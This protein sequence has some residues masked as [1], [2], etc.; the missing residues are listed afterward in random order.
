MGANGRSLSCQ[1]S[2]LR[3]DTAESFNLAECPVIHCHS[4]YRS[5]I[6]VKVGQQ[7]EGVNVVPVILIPIK[8][9][10]REAAFLVP[11]NTVSK[12]PVPESNFP[13]SL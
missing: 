3:G 8:N 12:I 1:C 4:T 10:S 2:T 13:D 9:L 6:G 5:P 11:S 7:Y